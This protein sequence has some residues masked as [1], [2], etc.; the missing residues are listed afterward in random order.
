METFHVELISAFAYFFIS[1]LVAKAPG[2]NLGKKLSNFRE[3]LNWLPTFCIFFPPKRD[4][5]CNTMR[6]LLFI[7]PENNSQKNNFF[8][9]V[10]SLT[11]LTRKDLC[12]TQFSTRMAGWLLLIF[13][14]CLHNQIN[15][16]HYQYRDL[17]TVI[18][19]IDSKNGWLLLSARFT[20]KFRLVFV[21]TLESA[22]S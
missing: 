16:F 10:S 7:L 2:L 3:P 21:L 14:I 8:I 1:N 9:P 5:Y 17:K 20:A 11:L 13:L 12:F 15:T 4:L 22:F 6:W 18:H 19:Q